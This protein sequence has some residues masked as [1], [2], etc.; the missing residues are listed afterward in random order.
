MGEISISWS[1]VHSPVIPG[2]A[3]ICCHHD[4]T[5]GAPRDTVV[6]WT[7]CTVRGAEVVVDTW[8]LHCRSSLPVVLVGCHK[9]TCNLWTIATLDADNLAADVCVASY[10]NGRMFGGV[11]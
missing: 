2:G 4:D 8:S 3:E 7:G 6:M 10:S 1:L 11:L 5:V 9:P